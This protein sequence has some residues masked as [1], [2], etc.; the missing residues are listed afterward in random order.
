MDLLNVVKARSIWLF[1]INDLNPRGKSIFPELVTWLKDNYSFS[2]VPSS[3]TDFDDTKALA[4]LDGQ[5]QA[6]EEIF[7]SVD[8][9][10]YTDGLIADTRSSTRDTDA[11]LKDV[12]DSATREFTL[13]HG[14]DVTRRTLYA[15]ELIVRCMRS[16]NGLNPKLMDFCEKISALAHVQN[17]SPFETFGIN[18]WN[19]I[20]TPNGAQHFRFERKLNVP[21]SENRYY[22]LAPLQT[23]DHLALLN[24]FETL[25]VA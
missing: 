25:L 19:A 9:R 16:L 10:V 22:S 2:K 12:L 20:P 5:F 1:D 18:F 17:K 7:L 13:S 24:E 4:F 8:L 15:S 3:M 21:G 23:E 6:K 11:F 14:S